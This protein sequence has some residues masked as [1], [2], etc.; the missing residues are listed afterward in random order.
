MSIEHKQDL[1]N[2]LA[3]KIKP[4]KIIGRG[5]YKY[6]KSAAS[7]WL[8]KQIHNKENPNSKI[9]DC[10]VMTNGKPFPTESKAMQSDSYQSLL[11]GKFG[12]MS[13]RAYVSDYGVM[14]SPCGNG[15]Y[16]G[17]VDIGFTK[18]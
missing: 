16:V 9:S 10:F 11:A 2:L 8:L 7:A 1:S 13:D 12:L 6:P 14:A 3:G 4:A 17:Y 15:G 18:Q 5:G